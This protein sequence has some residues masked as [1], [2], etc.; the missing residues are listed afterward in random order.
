VAANLVD[1]LLAGIAPWRCVLCRDVAHGID[2]CAACINDLPW[3]G[4]C[5]RHCALPLPEPAARVCGS[6]LGAGSGAAPPVNPPIDQC[7][8]ALAY[9]YPLDRLITGL[10]YH[11]KMLF[12]RVLGELLAI[13]MHEALAA[14]EVA[15]PMQIVPVP[16]HRWRLAQR[17]YN[18]AEQIAR[19]LAHEHG[20]P[21]TS[22]LI[23]RVRNT[24]P[25]TGKSRSAR[26][27]N[28]RGAFRVCGLVE[29]QRIALVD[30]VITTASTVREIARLLKH[31][32]AAEVQVWAVARTEN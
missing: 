24:P 21:L 30:D 6:C 25:Q 20:I 23:R 29:Q 1:S 28:I 12:A 3:L 9:E 7:I 32:G 15:L 8:A 22:G 31:H 26:L 10:K 5:C 19:W 4:N 27:R 11:R 18:Q 13:R 14:R 17:G 16:M 2:I